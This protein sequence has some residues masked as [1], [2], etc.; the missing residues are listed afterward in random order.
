MTSTWSISEKG[1][2]RTVRPKIRISILES[3]NGYVKTCLSPYKIHTITA[4]APRIAAVTAITSARLLIAATVL[5][6][7]RLHASVGIDQRDHR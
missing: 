6:S 7:K 4:A 5:P 1:T 2:R 3:C